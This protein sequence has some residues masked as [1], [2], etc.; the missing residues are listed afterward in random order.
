MGVTTS[1]TADSR[2]SRDLCVYAVRC[3]GSYVYICGSGSGWVVGRRAGVAVPAQAQ[4]YVSRSPGWRRTTD[5]TV[6]GRDIRQTSRQIERAEKMRGEER[7]GE[8]GAE[9]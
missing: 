4:F 5:N 2:L 6:V 1:I 3:S 7:R 9:G 8:R